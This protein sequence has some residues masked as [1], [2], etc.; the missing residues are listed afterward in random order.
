MSKWFEV[1]TLTVTDS[2]IVSIPDTLIKPLKHLFAANCLKG[3]LP[4]SEMNAGW[5]GVKV[6]KHA[7]EATH[8][9]SSAGVSEQITLKSFY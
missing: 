1:C 7:E 6:G 3:L 8:C 2:K 5:V 9:T 4:L